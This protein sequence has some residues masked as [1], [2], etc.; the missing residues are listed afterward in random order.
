MSIIKKIL[1]GLLIFVGVVMLIVIV[2]IIID[3]P[4]KQP[5]KPILTEKP[6]VI[7]TPS[8][9]KIEPPHSSNSYVAKLEMA[10]VWVTEGIEHAFIR[11]LVAEPKMFGW[12]GDVDTHIKTWAGHEA[13][14]IAIRAGYVNNRTGEEIRIQTPGKVAFVLSNEGGKITVQKIE[15]DGNVEVKVPLADNF[16]SAKF[17]TPGEFEY[18]FKPVFTT[19]TA[20]PTISA[21]MTVADKAGMEIKEINAN[22]QQ[23]QQEIESYKQ[24][25][26]SCMSVLNSGQDV[27][28]PDDKIFNIMFTT[29]Q[30][31]WKLEEGREMEEYKPPLMQAVK[32]KE[33]VGLELEIKRTAWGSRAD[34]H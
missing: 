18:V 10:T 11:Q 14:L 8:A 24:F 22:L 31:L 23:L 19:A 15:R 13:H 17:Q 16:K 27:Q 7:E 32:R 33:V 34:N 4:G 21:V 28:D 29:L 26:N 25:I 5:T 9:I 30:E 6:K 2:C 1:K 12:T 3:W 20:I